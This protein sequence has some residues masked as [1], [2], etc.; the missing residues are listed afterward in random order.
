MTGG[1]RPACH[2]RGSELEQIQFLLAYAW[3]QTREH[4]LGCKQNLR[5]ILRYRILCKLCA[6]SR[7]PR[8]L[9]SNFLVSCYALFGA[10][11]WDGT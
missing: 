5:T 11:P 2:D 4:Y 7:K 9:Q 3:V 8:A 10:W 1:G 6:G